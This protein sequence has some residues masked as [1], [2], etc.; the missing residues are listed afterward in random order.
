MGSRKRKESVEQNNI[1]ESRKLS[2]TM[3]EKK[4]KQLDRK[5]EQ[6]AR[7]RNPTSKFLVFQNSMKRKS[8]SNQEELKEKSSEP[9]IAA[10]S[11]ETTS[12]QHNTNQQQPTTTTTT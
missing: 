3:L 6:S 11:K 5:E 8:K 12:K 10:Q 9:I 4:A 7:A 1:Q 2:S